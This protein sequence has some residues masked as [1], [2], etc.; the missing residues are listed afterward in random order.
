MASNPSE[1]PPQ[2]P[3]RSPLA[4]DSAATGDAAEILCEGRPGGPLTALSF[5]YP[6]DLAPPEVAEAAAEFLVAQ[7]RPAM[8]AALSLQVAGGHE[9]LTAVGRYV[10]LRPEAGRP[11][12][13]QP[14]SVPERPCPMCGEHR[15]RSRRGPAMIMCRN[16]AGSNLAASAL[17]RRHGLADTS[18]GARLLRGG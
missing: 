16:C 12:K 1:R 3:S 11:S 7:G 9:A 4:A 17:E 15:I 2:T 6:E 5:A 18:G 14:P 10:H 13:S 8:A